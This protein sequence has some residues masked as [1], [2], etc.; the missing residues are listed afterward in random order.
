MAKNFFLYGTDLGN[1]LRNCLRNCDLRTLPSRITN[2]RMS[3]MRCPLPPPVAS[4]THPAHE[5]AKC[6]SPVCCDPILCR[7]QELCFPGQHLLFAALSA[8]VVSI[9]TKLSTARTRASWRY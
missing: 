8:E 3:G 7:W 5:R 4:M 1:C 6:R 9:K 2:P